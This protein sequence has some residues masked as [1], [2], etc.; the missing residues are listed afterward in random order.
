MK[1]KFLFTILLVLFAIFSIF[2]AK[3]MSRSI[4]P[5]LSAVL[6]F[7]KAKATAENYGLQVYKE[8]NEWGK[9]EFVAYNKANGEGVVYT[10]QFLKSAKRMI[11]FMYYNLGG[12]CESEI[13][14]IEESNTIV[15]RNFSEIVDFSTANDSASML[16]H[17]NYTKLMAVQR[18]IIKAGYADSFG[19]EF[20]D[21]INPKQP[22]VSVKKKDDCFYFEIEAATSTEK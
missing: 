14:F 7:K 17:Q 15:L 1:K 22:K 9:V 19:M 4:K 13:N 12:K 2:P 10:Y 11:E 3:K 21:K 18:E 20:H 6:T 8:Q 5:D 16:T